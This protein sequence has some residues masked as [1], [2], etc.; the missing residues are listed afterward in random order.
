M[1]PPAQ[2]YPAAVLVAVQLPDVD[3]VQHAA[4]LAE[5]GRLV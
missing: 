5:L 4:D 1:P 3:N 2:E